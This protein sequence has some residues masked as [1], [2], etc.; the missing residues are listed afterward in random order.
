VSQRRS[1]Y[2]LKTQIS[3]SRTATASSTLLHQLF[4]RPIEPTLDHHVQILLYFEINAHHKTD[5]NA[6]TMVQTNK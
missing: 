1:R 3:S 6:N 5:I 4:Q 2:P